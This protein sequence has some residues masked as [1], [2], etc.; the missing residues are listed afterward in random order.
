MELIKIN[1]VSNHI[2]DWVAYINIEELIAIDPIL[3]T[4]N[5]DEV[6]YKLTMSNAYTYTITNEEFNDLMIAINISNNR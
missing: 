2:K 1:L 3:N 6:H 5:P 4:K